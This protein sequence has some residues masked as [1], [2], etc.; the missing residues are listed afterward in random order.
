M[1]D[2]TKG[3]KQYA[4]FQEQHAKEAAAEHLERMVARAHTIEDQANKAGV[5]AVLL[6]TV[7]LTDAIET[8][9]RKLK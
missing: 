8:L 9:A 2:I 1:S 7:F 6:A 4:E 5:S 3:M